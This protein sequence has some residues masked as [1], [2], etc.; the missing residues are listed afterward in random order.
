MTAVLVI[1]ASGAGYLGRPN[2]VVAPPSFQQLTFSRGKI[3]RAR[4]APD[5]QTVI[6]N[7]SWDGKPFEVFSIRLDTAESTALPLPPETLLRSVSLSG[8][9]AV[10]VKEHILAKV[11]IGGA[12]PRD[13]REHVFDADWA[14]DG[15]FALVRH[16]DGRAWVEYPEGKLIYEPG[17]GVLRQGVSRWL[18]DRS[19]RTGRVRRGP[20][21]ADHPRSQGAVVAQSQKR[22]SN[23]DAPFAWTPDGREVWFT[24][25]DVVGRSAVHAMTPDGRERVV[26]R[27]M[28]S[29]RILDIAP[30]GRVLL[31]NDDYRADMSLVDVNAPGERDL[32]WKDWSRPTALSDDGKMLAFG[33]GGRTTADGRVLGY[34][35]PTDGSPAV[36]LSEEGNPHAFSPDGKWVLM[37][38]P[39]AGRGRVS[40]TPIGAGD[41]R[42]LDAGRVAGFQSQRRWMPDGRRIVFVGREAGKSNRVFIQSIDAGPPEPLTPEGAHGP[43]IVSPESSAVIVKNEKGQL[44]RYSVKGGAPTAV[45]GALP[46]DEPLAWSP[47][48]DSIWVLNRD[49]KPAKI[50]RIELRSGRRSLWRDVPYPD[51]AAIDFDSLRVVMS[52]DGTKFVYGYQTHQSGLYVATGLR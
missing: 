38:G 1:A 29:M 42:H 11:P 3:A 5:W 50:F 7:A 52:A 19:L 4:F 37:G 49:T 36:L 2:A 51:P 20:R 12:A 40:I 34:V 22:A 16:K 28:G 25:S 8:D 46:R 24:A 35:R 13:L 30:D 44:S 15:S 6:G 17:S 39:L 41:T 43:M 21:V 31:T 27:A 23:M 45:A 48:G 14:P 26:H 33:F 9:L 47:R 32:T 10:I 18:D